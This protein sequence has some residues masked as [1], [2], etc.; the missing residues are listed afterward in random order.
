M[1][2]IANTVINNAAETLPGRRGGSFY[3]E[4]CADPG[5]TTGNLPTTASELR[6]GHAPVTVS[7]TTSGAIS[8]SLTVY[9]LP[10]PGTLG[11]TSMTGTCDVAPNDCVI[12]IFSTN[13]GTNPGT[14]ALPKLFSAPFQVDQQSDFG[15]GQEQGLNPGDG[16]P[17]VPLAVGLPL[18]A[19]A[20][21]GGWTLRNRRR[22]RQAA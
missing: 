10:D 18:A 5:G 4:M 15:S 19:V 8:K 22:R 1:S 20:V 7:K 11:S 17:E 9:D 21:F 2:T 16:T 14:F 13:P 3:L 12:G 6:G